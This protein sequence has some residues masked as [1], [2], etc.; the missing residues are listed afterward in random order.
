MT[1]FIESMKGLLLSVLALTFITDIFAQIPD[2]L[3]SA[4]LVAWYPFNGNANDESGVSEDGQVFNL[5]TAADR[6][7]NP[8]SAFYFSGLNCSPHIETNIDFQGGSEGMTISYWLNRQG[9]GCLFPRIFGFW[10]GGNN[11]Q[12]WGMAWSNSGNLDYTGEAPQNNSWHHVVVTID[13]DSIRAYLNN[14]FKG[15][16]G[17]SKQ[18][19]L[20]S[21][22][23]IGRMTH[24][25]YDAFNGYL[26]DFGIWNR[27]L[28]EA[29]ITALYTADNASL[30]GE[31]NVDVGV[32]D[33]DDHI[34][35]TDS[36]Y[37]NLGQTSFTA[38][39]RFRPTDLSTLNECCG[40]QTL[41]AKGAAGG[42]GE[43]GFN[44]DLRGEPLDSRIKCNLSTGPG[45]NVILNAPIVE[46]EWYD[47]VFV[48]DWS[49][50]T[51]TLFVNGEEVDEGS[52]V[53]LGNM[54]NGWFPTIGR[55]VW[56][57]SDSFDGHFFNGE[58]DQI[59]VLEG[60]DYDLGYSPCSSRENL[61]LDINEFTA[62]E[63]ES[64]VTS[65]F[66]IDEVISLDTPCSENVHLGC[67]DG[68]ACNYDFEA[69]TDDGS[70]IYSPSITISGV[71]IGDTIFTDLNQSITFSSNSVI[72][73]DSILLDEFSVSFNS[74]SS[75]SI[76]VS[77]ISKQY[78]LFVTGRFGVADGWSHC[79]PAFNYQWDVDTGTKVNCDGTQ[80]AL[81]IVGW[82]YDGNADFQRPDNDVDN[83]D[84]FCSGLDKTYFWTI[85]GDGNSHTVGFSDC[86]YGDN[87][88][89]LNFSF[90]ELIPANF[91]T[92]PDGTVASTWTYAATTPG[93]FNLSAAQDGCSTDFVIVVGGPGC[94]DSTACNYNPSATN[95]DGSCE[96]GGCTDSLACNYDSS[97]LCD[98]GSC[99]IASVEWDDS[100]VCDEGVLIATLTHPVESSENRSLS[101]GYGQYV[102][103]PNSPSLSNFPNGMT[104]ECWYWQ[105]G[106][107]GGDETIVGH[108]YF[109]EEGFSI[110]NAH[111]TW[112]A[113][114]FGPDTTA[115][116]DY[117]NPDDYNP[118]LTNGAW[119]HVAM[120]YDG[121]IT[122][123]FLNGEL[124]DSDTADVGV[125]FSPGF[126]EDLVI[127]RHT[128]GGGSSSSSRLSGKLDELRVSSISR[129]SENFTP[130]T[131]EF[132]DDSY[133]VALF[134]FNEEGGAVVFDSSEN[135]N[136]GNC[137]GTTWSDSSPILAV[138][139]SN[140]SVSWEGGD[141]DGLVVP[142]D[143]VGTVS[144]LVSSSNGTCML[145]EEIP[146]VQVVVGC[147]DADACN[148][149]IDATCDEGTCI[150]PPLGA[151]DCNS[152]AEI[153]GT[154]TTWDF[155]TQTCVSIITCGEGTTWDAEL[156]TCI[157]NESCP[158]ELDGDGVIGASDLLQF[159]SM[160]GSVCAD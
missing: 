62:V 41:L 25:A 50:E 98:D 4:D 107:S 115:R 110:E 150:Y 3:P 11:A 18:L 51:A 140:Y 134:H 157:C 46:N 141:S 91:L 144:A 64:Q 81:D 145:Q 71:A 126:D 132:L 13:S 39:V 143:S 47:L 21:Y 105:D 58:I 73:S 77:E 72:P 155:D 12:S 87:S 92:W 146:T 20:A 80:D 28:S 55:Y 158:G 137:L 106:F 1:K 102:R 42:T 2:Y 10:N 31:T 61:L 118:P 68:A 154:G 148:Y 97:A 17:S 108:E 129:Y 99:I 83:N 16:F 35:L 121:N 67:T 116:W 151:S 142:S 33:G 60:A 123:Y 69:L 128:W 96:S 66:D 30:L 8:E 57:N 117:W 45:A 147:T 104:L 101:F 100:H 138:P 19:P 160:F 24:P 127:N 75:H 5:S 82:H 79:D 43:K 36:D 136:H 152:G 70:C 56:D 6:F 84:L 65:V 130:P 74:Y 135:G 85:I 32:F 86:C 26:D 122:R 37:L 125:V 89:S 23:S 63:V 29:E 120:T 34:W 113:E 78:R 54:N 131:T 95:D 7:G 114:I 59:R 52:L 94:M 112:A 15:A 27:T 40:Y 156:Q 119:N 133:T 22:M 14:E 88:G 48:V 111:G 124:M 103:I 90:Y 93:T 53:G 38:H 9:S 153:C 159:L 76:P 44:I 49:I 109:A 139:N 149:Q